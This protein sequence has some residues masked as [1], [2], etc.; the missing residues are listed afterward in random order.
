MG[1]AQ[2][3]WIDQRL[4]TG[5]TRTPTPR[6]TGTAAREYAKVIK[7]LKKTAKKTKNDTK[8]GVIVNSECLSFFGGQKKVN[9][10]K[11]A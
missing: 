7:N 9:V 5:S 2:R 10:T 8:T 1:R 6:G 3:D 4:S 11:M